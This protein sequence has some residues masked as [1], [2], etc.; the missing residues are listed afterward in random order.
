MAVTTDFD[1]LPSSATSTGPRVSYAAWP[2]W[3]SRTCIDVL[4]HVVATTGALQSGR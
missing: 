2:G 1:E 4:T 3:W